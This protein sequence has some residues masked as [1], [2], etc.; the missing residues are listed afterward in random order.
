MARSV[1]FD[2]RW[3]MQFSTHWWNFIFLWSSQNY[4][5][6]FINYTYSL[7]SS[8]IYWSFAWV[9]QGKHN[10]KPF[11]I[12]EV[13]VCVCDRFVCVNIVP[14][15]LCV[16]LYLSPSPAQQF[17]YGMSGWV[18][19]AQIEPAFLLQLLLLF[20][21]NP[22]SRNPFYCHPEEAVVPHCVGHPLIMWCCHFLWLGRSRVRPREGGGGWWDRASEEEAALSRGRR[23]GRGGGRG[24]CAAQL[25]QLPAG[26]RVAERSHRTQD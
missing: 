16:P 6:G 23:G 20:L 3:L 10:V 5:P 12:T 25:R 4:N 15:C 24:A 21:L 18:T 26:V 1:S 13:C 7:L 14:P 11:L 8:F 22:E 17:C 2:R 9:K 19:Q